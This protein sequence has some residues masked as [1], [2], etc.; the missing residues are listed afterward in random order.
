MTSPDAYQLVLLT[1]P[2]TIVSEYLLERL[3]HIFQDDWAL[4]RSWRLRLGVDLQV[5]PCNL[6]IVGS[7]CSGFSLNPN[8]KLS[9]FGDHSDIDVAVISDYHF[10]VS[11]RTLRNVPLAEARTPKERQALIDHRQ[12]LIYWGCVAADKV[13]RFLPSAKS[14]T[15]A[16]SNMAVESPTEGRE[17]K[18]RIY[19]DYDALSLL[20]HQRREETS[21]Q[22]GR[23]AMTQN[24]LNSTTHN[25][26]WIQKRYIQD[27]ITLEAP[28]QRNPVW[29]TKQKAYLIDTILRG[30]P[31]PELYIQ[32]YTDAEGND[33][34]VVVDGQQRIRACVEYVAGEFGLDREDSPE[35]AEMKFDDLGEVYKKKIY[36]YNFVVRTLPEMDHQ[37]LREMF[38]RL[39]RNTIALNSQELR[40]ATYWGEFIGCVEG[41]AEDTR[42]TELG[43]FTP[44]DVRRMLDIE[45][46]SELLIGHLHGIQNKKDSLDGYYELYEQEFE[47][48]RRVESLF[49]IIL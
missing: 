28:F 32:E 29:T 44:N 9:P 35:W 15:V 30:Y 11:W 47:E 46:I 39:N 17:I 33:V 26:A 41:L 27:E 21:R 19:K 6:S 42:W 22:S 7:S 12:R 16:A 23:R 4:Y 8:K 49:N 40:H 5:D 13:L 34:Y 20:S 38:Q 3:P 37:Q 1:P 45:Y 31:I 18:L 48:R 43:V 10:V 24:F 25:I 14:W 2:A 36:S